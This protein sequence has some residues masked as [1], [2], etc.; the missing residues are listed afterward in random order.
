MDPL[1][2]KIKLFNNN[3]SERRSEGFRGKVVYPLSK[4]VKGKAV[5]LHAMEA[6][7]RRGGIASTLSR[8]RH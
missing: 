5:P 3:F 8:P 2:K 4:K 7:G 1:L 6:L